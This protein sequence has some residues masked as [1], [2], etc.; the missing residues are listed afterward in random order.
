MKLEGQASLS[1]V[2][3]NRNQF[4]QLVRDLIQQ[5]IETCETALELSG[6]DFSDLDAVYMSGGSSHVPAVLEAVSA[7]FGRIP[8]VAVPP[9]KAVVLGAA[10]YAYLLDAYALHV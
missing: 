3:I 8:L 7:A 5:T 4:S 6:L 1:W 9:E 2:A 10:R